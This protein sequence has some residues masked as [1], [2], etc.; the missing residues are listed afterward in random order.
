MDKWE[1]ALIDKSQT[2]LLL[3]FSYIPDDDFTE[4]NIYLLIVVLHFKFY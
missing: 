4:L 2:G 1:F 3:G